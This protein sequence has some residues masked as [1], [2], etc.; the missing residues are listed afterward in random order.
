MSV[1]H[2]RKCN[3]AIGSL[4]NSSKQ[5]KMHPR[6][7]HESERCW[8]QILCNYLNRS[9]RLRTSVESVQ[10]P[11][12]K[13]RKQSGAASGQLW[14]RNQQR[15]MTWTVH[16]CSTGPIFPSVTVEYMFNDKDKVDQSSDCIKLEPRPPFASF[17]TFL[18]MYCSPGTVSLLQTQY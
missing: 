4:Y 12:R 7:V 2:H 15:L 16:I 9:V 11:L 10:K 1:W 6:A 18:I 3:L 17:L 5:I 14:G 8:P 13:D